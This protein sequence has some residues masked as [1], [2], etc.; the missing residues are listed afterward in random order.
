MITLVLLG[1]WTSIS[2]LWAEDLASVNGQ[3]ITAEEFEA[4]L[5]G[6]TPQMKMHYMSSA[7]KAEFLDELIVREVVLQEGIRLG[8]DKD[9]ETLA[10]LE[11]A[12]RGILINRMFERIMNEKLGDEQVKK[13]YAGH[14]K[15]FKQVKASHI[16]VDQE[17]EA[18]EIYK[19][20][21]GG[22][23]FAELAKKHSKDP[24]SRDQGGDL[25]YFTRGQ[26]V[27]SFEDMAFS[28]KVDKISEP[29]QTSFGYHI[30]KVLDIKDPK[31]FE[32]LSP[33]DLN[34][35]KRQMFNDEIERLKK[36]AKIVIHKDRIK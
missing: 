34:T 18:K 23:D 33:E 5:Q 27:K 12:K 30:I 35:V 22:A 11:E 20:L 19:R 1:F 6:L 8:L 28:L 26:M 4:K 7:G 10:R 25:G 24:S 21:K 13:Y 2:P 14:Q 36:S 9:Q 31:K 29:V 17:Q 32:E 15:E 16:L 3:A